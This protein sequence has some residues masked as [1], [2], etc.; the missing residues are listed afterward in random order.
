MHS[1]SFWAYSTRGDPPSKEG[2]PLTATVL[3]DQLER[4]AGTLATNR[5]SHVI[6][7]RYI[8]AASATKKQP[9]LKFPFFF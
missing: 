5:A 6:L 7:L 4:I 8:P 2:E 9:C 1:K 3:T